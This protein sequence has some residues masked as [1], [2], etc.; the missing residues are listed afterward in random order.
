MPRCFM[1][2]KQLK[3]R[4]GLTER[5]AGRRSP[6]P[7]V[8]LPPPPPPP[9]LLSPPPA[10]LERETNGDDEQETVTAKS[11]SNVYRPPTPVNHTGK[12]RSG[13]QWFGMEVGSVRITALSAVK[14][15]P[16]P[17]RESVIHRAVRFDSDVE[18]ATT[19]LLQLARRTD[20]PESGIGSCSEEE[21]HHHHHLVH[22]P[23]T[24]TP[25]TNPQPEETN[26]PLTPVQPPSS[27]VSPT[28][29]NEV[30]TSPTIRQHPVN[31]HHHLPHIHH[32]H[33][34][35][36]AVGEKRYDPNE[37]YPPVTIE[38]VQP[39][40]MPIPISHVWE[41][42]RP[43][44]LY[45]P[46][47]TSVEVQRRVQP[48][49]SELS[50]YHHLHHHHLHHHQ[51]SPQQQVSGVM[52]DR[53]PQDLS[54]AHAILD[55][56]TAHI[57]S[58][59]QQLHHHHHHHQ[60]EEE[61]ESPMEITPDSSKTPPPSPA[62][63]ALADPSPIPPALENDSTSSS[64]HCSSSSSSS[65]GGAS[66]ESSGHT[67]ANG[68]NKSATSKTVA[69]TYEAFFVS[70][71]RSKRRNNPSAQQQG[72]GGSNS[73]KSG[74]NSSDSG[75][76]LETGAKHLARAVSSTEKHGSTSS[77]PT[78]NPSS[79]S[80][81][82]VCGECG[83]A[84]A[85][86]SN[87]SR[88]KQTHRSLESG[89]ARTCPTCGKAY[90]SMPALSMHLLT[91]ALSHVCPVCSKA[92][93]RPW[94]LQGHMRS[95]TGEKPYG[96]AHCGKAFADR[97]N[98]RAHMQTHSATKSHHCGKCHKAFA[99]KS[100]LNKHL[101]SSCFRDSPTPSHSESSCDSMGADSHMMSIDT[102]VTKA[103]PVT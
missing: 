61:S 91:H 10:S 48:F 40:A 65:I 47:S 26:R 99:L 2:K 93:S 25:T 31:L 39:P 75:I 16:M 20:T 66:T 22:H 32:H 78:P 90:V 36:Y 59:Q 12:C 86:S 95:H 3:N 82:Y 30:V 60:D 85:T 9:P 24:T 70:D 71:G 41:R 103:V 46:Y 64:S 42:E 68:G 37:W 84:Y 83:K 52:M 77:S 44:D 5:A 63:M 27:P 72:S 53:E 97:S 58:S 34:P 73:S 4:Q 100:Y 28:S 51:L 11:T 14:G 81:R 79:R 62:T 101:E 35:M 94:L 102:K 17:A 57:R 98:L 69:Y 49:A 89:C 76:H 18:E 80:G 38:P 45:R 92:F 55:L 54:T 8:D 56:S 87:L 74:G 6:S 19:G 23:H 50:S 15:E 7:C 13:G 88:H 43:A 67:R 96:C 29:A 33:H 1:P 21:N